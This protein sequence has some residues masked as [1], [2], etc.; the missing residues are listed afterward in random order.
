MGVISVNLS[1]SLVQIIRDIN[2]GKTL[3]KLIYWKKNG[4]R[5]DYVV[6]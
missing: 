6:R 4:K 1:L 5:K 2:H 3:M